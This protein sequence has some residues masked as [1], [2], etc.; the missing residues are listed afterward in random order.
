MHL[1]GEVK[2]ERKAI[3]ILVQ[4]RFP[5]L[6]EIAQQRIEQIDSDE[7]LMQLTAQLATAPDEAA[8]RWALSADLPGQ[9]VGQG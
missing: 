7:K 1:E 6:I 5:E 8:A 4:A 2:G 9:G 3:I